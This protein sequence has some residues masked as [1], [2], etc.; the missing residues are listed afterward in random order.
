MSNPD[1]TIYIKTADYKGASTDVSIYITF[2]DVNGKKSRNITLTDDIF[3]G[4]FEKGQ[5]NKFP[6]SDISGLAD[7]KFIEISRGIWGF[8]GNWFCECVWVVNEQVGGTPAPV[9]FPINRWLRQ[10]V[11]LKIQKWDCSLPQNDASP[12]Q[13]AKEIQEK[14]T[15]YVLDRKFPGVPAQV[16]D[17]PQQEMFTDHYQNDVLILSGASLG[18]VGNLAKVFSGDWKSV[19]DISNLYQTGC[20]FDVPQGRYR[21]DEDSYFAKQR[22]QG[23]NPVI[24]QLCTKIP[25]AL[26]V[27]NDMLKPFLEGYTLDDAVSK[28]KIFLCDLSMLHSVPLAGVPLDKEL[29]H[30]Y[31]LFYLNKEDELTPVAIQLFATTDKRYPHTV[32]LPTDG[33][34]WKLAKMFYNNA[35]AMV[36]QSSTHLGF[37]HLI[38]ESIAV[39]V[40]RT[41]SMSHPLHRLIAPHFLYLMAINSLAITSLLAPDGWID[42]TMTAGR[43]GVLDIIAHQFKVWRLNVEGTLPEEIKARKLDDPKI[44]PD[45][46]YRD[47]GLLVWNCIKNYVAGVV[48]G[49]YKN[50]N[51]IANDFE[52]QNFAEILVAPYPEGCEIKGVPGNGKF[53]TQEEIISAFTSFIFTSSAIHAAVNFGQYDEYGFPP[54]YPAFMNGKAPRDKSPITE[55]DLLKQLPNKPMIQR[56]TESLG[57]FEVNY[58]YDPVGVAA[59]KQF[60][61]ELKEASAIIDERNKHRR[62]AYNHLNPK[63]I[64]NAISI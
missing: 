2:I 20:G 45:Y 15:H 57:D 7:L 24:M 62:I 29:V 13:R 11:T 6:V 41:L 17:L 28:N 61:I 40:N 64:P 33:N 36:H 48:N 47:D 60:N 31:A 5:T 23:C 49:H 12:Q 4:K 27:T 32:F 46:P 9:Y 1:Y 54:N 37:T 50:K 42:T 16:K 8:G 63:N 14:Q 22:T 55:A 25:S 21:W 52:L 26:D 10:Y 30:P 19:D 3:G 53:E 18:I 59:L 34:V 35:D 43:D 38:I 56:A 51:D 39:A 44:L 58:T